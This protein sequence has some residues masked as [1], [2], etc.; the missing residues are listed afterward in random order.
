MARPSSS[1]SASRVGI[2]P[3]R[4]QRYSGTPVPAPPKRSRRPRRRG[5]RPPP[6]PFRRP[7]GPGAARQCGGT[8]RPGEGH[9]QQ[10]AVVPGA[11]RGALPLAGEGLLHRAH[12]PLA[13]ELL[14]VGEGDAGLFPQQGVEL[15]CGLSLQLRPEG[16]VGP[17][18]GEGE[19][20]GHRPDVQPVPPTRKGVFPRDRMPSMAA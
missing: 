6:P 14:P 4:Y 11:G 18:V 8:P 16:R 5:G 10:Q 13:V 15:R 7:G 20:L 17:G 12:K 9:P 1:F 3:V 19:A 2:F